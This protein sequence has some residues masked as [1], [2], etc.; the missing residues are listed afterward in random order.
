[1]DAIC[2][3]GT[4]LGSKDKQRSHCSQESC[5]LIWGMRLIHDVC[6]KIDRIRYV[7]EE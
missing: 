7:K 1:M 6:M 4:Q 2:I 3:Q 5:K